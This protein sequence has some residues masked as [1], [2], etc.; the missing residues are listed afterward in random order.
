MTEAARPDPFAG[1]A[2]LG[3]AERRVVEDARA[4]RETRL[5]DGARPE[6]PSPERVVRAGLLRRLATGGEGIVVHQRGLHVVGAWIAGDG[7][8]GAETR[9]IDLCGCK[10]GCFLQIEASTLPDRVLM[11]GATLPGLSLKASALPAGFEGDVMEVAGFATFRDA[12]VAGGLNLIGG[13]FRSI[14]DLVGLSARQ[15]REAGP[16]PAAAEGGADPAFEFPALDLSHTTVEADLW[17]WEMRLDGPLDLTRADLKGNAQLAK[18]T[19]RAAGGAALNA[20]V[21]RAG[22]LSLDGAQV[23]GGA[24]FRAAHVAGDFDAVGASFANPGGVALDLDRIRIDGA[25]FLRNGTAVDGMLDLTAAS[26]GVL[27]DERAC[28]PAKG[29][30]RLDRCTYR[31]FV[32]GAPTSA[33][34][35]IAWLGLLDGGDFRPQPYEQCARV[36]RETGH[37]T[38]A[39]AILIAK[40]RA[41]RRAGLRARATLPGKAAHW[42]W[43]RML[44]MTAYGHEPWRA[45]INVVVLVAAGTALLWSNADVMLLAKR[46]DPPAAGVSAPPPFLPVVYAVETFIPLV[47]FGQADAFRPD[48]TTDRGTLVQ[49]GLWLYGLI[50]WIVGGA[51]AA[52]VG[53]LFRRS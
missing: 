17:A 7:P 33:A 52:G 12:E 1:F 51:A 9:G 25:L 21:L 14:L 16:P 42:A 31:A 50:G 22:L 6:A 15:G 19:V 53:R 18:L 30:L 47:K 13:R 10:V 38:D 4:G 39:T 44:E 3:P 23:S 35:R 2:P 27:C 5:G 46:P 32:G 26:I 8:E 40:E 34:D 45:L 28:W 41:L 29:R 11:R 24:V 48:M 36:L 49:Y 20:S 37:E 43:T